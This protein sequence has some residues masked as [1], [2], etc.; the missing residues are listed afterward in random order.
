MIRFKGRSSIKQYMPQKP[1]KRGYKVWVRAN[2]NGYV[3]QFEV[4]TGKIGPTPE[5][6]LGPRV[7][8]TLTNKLKDR[9]HKVYFDN[10][11]TSVQLMKDL[12][13][14]GIYA[15]GTVRK[16]RIGMPKAFEKE[17]D[18][19][20]GEFQFRTS[21]QGII[22]VFGRTIKGFYSCQIFTT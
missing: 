16:G 13:Q 22:T 5:K 9:Y 10:Y 19:A 11:F 12:K 7:V 6:C 20:R 3:S 18:M 2:E 14:Q 1:I 15:C 4:Y 8:K 17:K 21:S